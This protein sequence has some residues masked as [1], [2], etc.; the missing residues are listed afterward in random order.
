M[1]AF[2]R[3]VQGANVIVDRLE[4]L[5]PFWSKDGKEYLGDANGDGNLDW[6]GERTRWTVQKLM[7]RHNLPVSAYIS[8]NINNLWIGDKNQPLREM[9]TEMWHR[10]WYLSD[11]VNKHNH[12][13]PNYFRSMASEP[14]EE[15][16]INW[17]GQ[18]EPTG[19][20]AASASTEDSRVLEMMSDTNYWD[21][22]AANGH[23]FQQT[24]PYRFFY[25]T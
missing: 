23:I 12:V 16:T 17:W 20:D 6:N 4:L 1:A 8:S 19:K 22:A 9:V 11:E 3:L 14:P 5:E 25:V 2:S 10:Y 21:L 24:N 13:V 7:D 15:V 18:R